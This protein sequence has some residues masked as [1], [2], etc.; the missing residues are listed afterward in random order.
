MNWHFLYEEIQMIKCT[1]KKL[2]FTT[3]QGD[4]NQN[5]NK[6]S[7]HITDTSIHWKVKEK[8]VL[9]R[10]W[11]ARGSPSFLVR[12]MTSP[13]FLQK[14]M[15]IP[16]KIRNSSPILSSNITL[17]NIPECPKTHSTNTFCT[18]I[19]IATL[20]TRVSISK[21]PKCTIKHGWI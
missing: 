6:L 18:S 19:F 10:Q 14:N 21:Q 12:M 5:N 8:L 20:L 17:G 15:K 16:Q 7:S 13:T 2:E 4:T 11:G 1:W 9:A 3:H